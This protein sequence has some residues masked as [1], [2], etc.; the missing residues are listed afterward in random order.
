MTRY[1]DGVVLPAGSEHEV[2][3]DFYVETLEDNLACLQWIAARYPD[4]FSCEASAC[5]EAWSEAERHYG[6]GH[7]DPTTTLR[8]IAVAT[9]RGELAADLQLLDFLR[10]DEPGAADASW[11][12]HEENIRLREMIQS[13]LDALQ[14]CRRGPPLAP[15]DVMA[16]ALLIQR[17]Q[18]VLEEPPA[19]RD[20]LGPL[21][22]DLLSQQVEVCRVEGNDAGER[23]A[24]VDLRVTARIGEETFTGRR[25][26]VVVPLQ[27]I[28][29]DASEMA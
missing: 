26:A 6:I 19:L 7:G 9:L 12:I 5:R 8:Q 20:P 18:A 22:H 21:S 23:R 28:E 3:H 2:F 29:S 16:K 10:G 13:L 27:V 11:R 25:E 4:E 14:R 15:I 17:A 24:V 1:E